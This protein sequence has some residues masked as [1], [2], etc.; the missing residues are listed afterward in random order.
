MIHIIIVR[1]NQLHDIISDVIITPF[2][3]YAITDTATLNYLFQQ[4]GPIKPSA[5]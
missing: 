4:T 1:H 3:G 5:Y 2:S